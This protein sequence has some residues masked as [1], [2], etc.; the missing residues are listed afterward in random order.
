MVESLK[1]CSSAP[2]DAS[3]AFMMMFIKA[4]VAHA[5]VVVFTP[6]SYIVSVSERLVC[7]HTWFPNHRPGGQS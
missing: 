3:R 6:F 1:V 5:L 4:T 2:S 7:H